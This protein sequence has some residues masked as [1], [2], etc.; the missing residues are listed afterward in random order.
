M[1][2][3]ALLALHDVHHRYGAL[4][5]LHGVD[6]QLH[7]GRTLALLG[8]SG[9][10]KT[11]L[12]HLA[13]GLIEPHEGRVE[14]ATEAVAV[15]FQQPRLL[16]W[17][18]TLANI[19]LPLRATGL[20]RSRALR[21]AA[22]MAQ[23]VGLDAR[24]QAAWPLQLSGGMQSRA[25][26][27]RALALA[28]ALLLADEPF[29]ALDIGLKAQMHALLLA[30]AAHHGTA[31]LMITHDPAEAVRLAHEVLVMA[32]A[33]G[34]VVHRFAPPGVPAQRDDA[35][36]LSASAALLSVPAVRAAFDLP[37]LAAGGDDGASRVRLLF[38]PGRRPSSG[39]CG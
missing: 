14:R 24:A 27:A 16:P 33:P 1:T 2:A 3:P 39:A 28:P 15:M 26:L 17:K 9:C 10:G 29:A 4:E 22:A 20:A 8:P 6:L 19:A 25:A 12:L 21:E 11:T 35:T 38:A 37:P 31:V 36:V 5:V 18:T 32:A 13:A 23:A 7:R 30:H 34:R